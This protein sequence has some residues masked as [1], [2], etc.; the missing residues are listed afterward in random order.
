[1]N[2]MRGSALAGLSGIPYRRD[3]IIRP[4]LDISRAEIEAYCE[5]NGLEYVIDSTNL[6]NK[7]TRNKIRHT[8]IPMIER[9]FNHDFIR[10]AARNAEIIKS[11]E[12]YISAVADEK[13]RETVKDGAA[14]IG[15][16]NKCHTAIARRIVRHMINDCVGISDISSEFIDKILT[17]T[18]KNKSGSYINLPGGADAR[19][20]YGKLIIAKTEK[21]AAYEYALP[22]DKD[23]YIKEAGIT[24][25][26]E[27]AHA[28]AHSAR[29]NDGAQYF[30]GVD[31]DKLIVR[32][33]RNG[34]YFY[35]AGM[36]GKKKL[37]DYF[38]DKKIP[39][40]EREKT[41]VIVSGDDIVYIVG[42][43]RDNRF[44]FTGDGIRIKVLK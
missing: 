24:L 39:R 30:S 22:L 27:Y 3:N 20:E 32:S 17:L 18:Q 36:N 31:T 37:K 5:E 7:Y 33:R 9:E 44:A 21:T 4:L 26:A 42:H 10:T 29:E 14:D 34:D 23:I 12:E 2:F 41:P 13:Y 43:R 25:R 15:A 6:G 16:L 11:E 1:M 28:H 8:L 38:I 40:H 35:P 19:V